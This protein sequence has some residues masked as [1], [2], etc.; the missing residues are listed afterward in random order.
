MDL[1]RLSHIRDA[2]DRAA[3][4][5]PPAW[6]LEAT[7]AVNPFLGQA[8]DDLATTAARLGRVAG[9]SITMPWRWYQDQITAGKITAGDLRDAYDATADTNRPS[10]FA[11]FEAAIDDAGTDTTPVLPTVAD[12]A[13]QVSGIDWPRFITERFGSWAASYFDQGQALWGIR[14]QQEAYTAWRTM[15]LHDLTPE[16][17]GLK[18][19]GAFIADIPD[20][21]S[22]LVLRVVERLGLS[23]AALDSYFHQLLTYL[24]GWAH[25]A[26]QRLWQAELVGQRDNT[27]TN[28]LA[29]RLV[30]EDALYQQ[31]AV[32]VT[33]AWCAARDGHSQPLKPTTQEQISAILQTAADYGEQSRLRATLAAAATNTAP[34][35]RA[36]LQT[37]FCIDVRSEVFRRC[38]EACDPGIQTLGFAGFFGLAVSHQPFASDVFEPHAPVLLNTAVNSVSGHHGSSAEF[39][40]QIKARAKR[41]WGRFKL[42]AVSS[43]AFVEATGPVYAGRLVRSALGF[44]DKK[45][46]GEHDHTPLLDPAMGLDDRIEAAAAI[47]RA[48]SLTDGFARLVVLAGHGAQ[49]VNNP[50]ESA[51]HCGACGG[52][53]GEVNGRLVSMVLNEPAVRQGLADKGITIPDDTLFV[54]ALHNTT[55]D[56]MTIFIQD[57]DMSAHGDDLAKAT[58]WYKKAGAL[59]RAERAERLPLAKNGDDI[60]RRSQDWSEVRPEWALAGCRAFIAAPRHR[61]AKAD[62]G[63]LAF[64]H[65]YDWRKDEGFGVLELIMTAPVVVASWISLQYYGSTVAPALFGGGNKLLHN[66]VGGIGVI[67]GNG[68]NLRTGLPW[69]SVHDGERYIHEPLRLAVVVE[70]PQQAISD[71]L[72]RH[73][74]VRDLFDNQWLHLLRLGENGQVVERYAGDLRWTPVTDRVPAA[75]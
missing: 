65:N 20:D 48:M 3:Q 45:A 32:D 29:I 39:N 17:Q 24:G 47:L 41:A 64:L 68:G 61:T 56:Q 7:V 15:A 57:V 35:N 49:A 12:L 54:G 58:Q 55:T 31:Y 6:S 38:L 25:V 5:I 75:A 26:R 9:Q 72:E 27:L 43:F 67:E 50:H 19:F 23:D 73:D 36:S 14:Q 1:K 71:I 74:H 16:I 4:A 8:Q 13:R 2:A 40:T 63:G 52:Y 37:A 11:T 60:T 21:P 44:T 59:T 70:A 51:L 18:S 53:T 46:C 30:W 33:D 42:A 22:A 66:V 28:L 34:S 69:Q 10:S 62:L